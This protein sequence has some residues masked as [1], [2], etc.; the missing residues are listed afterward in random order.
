MS[1]HKDNRVVV[2]IGPPASG[3]GVQSNLLARSLR[4]TH[5]SSGNALRALDDPYIKSLMLKGDNVP[6]KY[7]EQVMSN[8]LANAPK[9]QPLILDGVT[10]KPNEIPWL[11]K[12]LS[13]NNRIIH[14]VIS[15][16]IDE[17]IA[18]QRSLARNRLDDTDKIF[19]HRWNVWTRNITA[20]SN[21]YNSM[22]V[23]SIV[24]GSGSKNEVKSRII[25]LL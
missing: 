1:E 9:D 3:K 14:K 2:I 18:R 16:N 17:S 24:D 19:A 4:G 10:R 11:I 22:G 20:I 23:F 15:I 13:I 5:I 21:I 7:F 8:A 12:Q 25:E 6:S